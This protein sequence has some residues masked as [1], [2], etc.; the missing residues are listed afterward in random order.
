MKIIIQKDLSVNADDVWHLLAE[1]FADIA[2]WTDGVVK[3][4]LD[5]PMALGTIRTCDLK[6]T[7]A[8]S[9]TVQERVTKF[10]KKTHALSYLIISGLP[11]FMRRV[12]NNWTMTQLSAGRSRITST[13][14]IKLAWWMLPM[15]PIIKRQFTKLLSG[16]ML[17]IQGQ[18]GRPIS[19]GASENFGGQAAQT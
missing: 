3:S 9:G 1:R 16:F 14:T 10:D 5:S 18:A 2:L 8:A 15:A 13:I 19:G 7:S 6:T 12:E 11:G 17:D 4:S